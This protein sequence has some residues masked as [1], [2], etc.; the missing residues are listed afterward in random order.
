M[1]SFT[2]IERL[3]SLDKP[4]YNYWFTETKVDLSRN[5]EL[6]S[7][8][9]GLE[10]QYD[11]DVTCKH[12]IMRKASMFTF[13]NSDDTSSNVVN[14]FQAPLFD[15]EGSGTRFVFR[16]LLSFSFGHA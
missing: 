10:H 7:Q 4:P 5:I 3:H 11:R 14:S 6:N 1:R 15:N 13:V 16:I 9:T 8:R 12:S 2:G